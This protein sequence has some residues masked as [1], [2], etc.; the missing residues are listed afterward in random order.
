MC[1]GCYES[2]MEIGPKMG[3]AADFVTWGD[4]TPPMFWGDSFPTGEYIATSR[5]RCNFSLDFVYFRGALKPSDAVKEQL[6]ARGDV[7]TK[8]W[9][10]LAH[11]PGADWASERQRSRCHSRRRIYVVATAAVRIE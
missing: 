7:E 2:G 4:V 3:H 6:R 11:S 8:K 1:A 9:A 10:H 5:R